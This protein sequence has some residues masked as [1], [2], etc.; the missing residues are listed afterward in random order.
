ME[1]GNFQLSQYF[2]AAS[3]F[4]PKGLEKLM[5]FSPC[6]SWSYNKHEFFRGLFSPYL[7]NDVN[8]QRSGRYYSA[9]AVDAASFLSPVE[10]H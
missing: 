5:G 10:A 9:D 7:E 3:L 4:V 6:H 2:P 8:Q 1:L